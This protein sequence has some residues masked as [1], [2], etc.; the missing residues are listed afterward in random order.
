MDVNIELTTDKQ[1][2]QTVWLL[3]RKFPCKAHALSRKRV[4]DH[5][6]RGIGR[7]LIRLG[8]VSSYDFRTVPGDNLPVPENEH[9]GRGSSNS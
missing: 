1:M 7:G 2:T 3:S 4:V 9:A 6:V 8:C 5:V